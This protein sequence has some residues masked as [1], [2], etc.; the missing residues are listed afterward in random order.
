MSTATAVRLVRA[1]GAPRQLGRQIGEA[2]APT[3]RRMAEN[4]RQ[5]LRS[6]RDRLK[7]RWEGALLQARKYHPYAAEGARPYLEELEGMAEGAGLSL[8]DLMVLNCIEGIAGDA[9]HLKCTSFAVSA[10]LTLDGHVLVG[11][12]E[13]WW[14]EDSETVYVV[15]ATPDEEPPF[16]ALTYGGLL[17]NI[18]LNAAGIAQCCDSVY[19]DDIRVGVPRIFV[20]RAVLGASRISEALERAVPPKRAAGY[21]HLIADRSGELYNL[22]A[23]AERFALHYGS[24]GSV[25]HTNHYLDPEMQRLEQDSE[26]L[27]ASRVRYHRAERLLGS[28]GPHSPDTFKAILADHVNHPRSICCHCNEQDAPLDRSQTIASVVMDLTAMTMSVAFGNPCVTE[29]E[30][31]SLEP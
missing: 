11:H 22:E 25:V 28:L 19:P 23:S 15:H 9:L 24:G 14:P 1:R 17:P 8:D 3:I 6:S 16:L 20:A 27:F 31:F 10:E 18:G 21:N 30:T 26:S 29:Y 4:Y 13:D 7:L 12:N 2:A 5:L